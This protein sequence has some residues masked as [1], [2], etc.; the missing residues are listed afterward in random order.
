VLWTLF[1]AAFL[2]TACSAGKSTILTPESGSQSASRIRASIDPAARKSTLLYVVAE[3]QVV[4]IDT[5]P[6]G[7]RVGKIVGLRAQGLC[8]DTKGDVFVTNWSP[9]D[10]VVFA[11]GEAKPLRTLDDSGEFPWA[12]AYDR[13]TGDLAVSNLFGSQNEPG[14]IAIYAHA[15]GTAHLYYPPNMQTV[16][17]GG[18][19]PDGTLWVDG[20]DAATTFQYDSFRRGTFTPVDLKGAR[21]FAPG[22]VQWSPKTRTMNVGDVR[23]LVVP[24]V[25]AVDNDGIVTRSTVLGCAQPSGCA[26][27]DFL[28]DGGTLLASE[29]DGVTNGVQLFGYPTGGSPSGEIRLPHPGAMVISR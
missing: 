20:L 15:S 12:C 5:Y 26:V 14:N 4:D 8:V 28:I 21:I 29:V 16:Y 25:Y 17:F 18:Y 13:A 6:D 1:P 22:S 24:R 27:A 2:L 19:A 9:G 11:H 10:V 7:K 23:S 3:N